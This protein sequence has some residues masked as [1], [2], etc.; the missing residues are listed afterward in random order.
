[1]TTLYTYDN[2]EYNG[3]LGNQLWQI[4]WMIGQARKNNGLWIVKPNWQ[5]REMFSL[6]EECYRYKSKTGYSGMDVV[7]GGT[8][9][10][11]ELKWWE[12]YED[13]IWEFFQPSD[14]AMLE[15]PRP[16]F[17]PSC[18]IHYRRGDYTG[19]PKHFP[20]PTKKYY[21]AA[22]TAVLEKEPN[23]KFYVFSD[24][25]DAVEQEWSFDSGM[26]GYLSGHGQVEF[27]KGADP[28]PVEVVDRKVAPTDWKDLFMMSEMDYNI[29]A[30]STFSWWGAYLSVSNEVYYPSKW[31]GPALKDTPWREGIPEDWTEIKC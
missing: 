22:M 30:N 20:A 2:L 8:A 7:D 18:S 11:Q 16:A 27:V 21:E 23:V 29:I 5:Y 4:A 19:L 26:R 9:Y 12:D 14:A 1:M 13:A 25:I 3:R 24:E 10:F 15:Y 6:P 31:F 17:A 28:T